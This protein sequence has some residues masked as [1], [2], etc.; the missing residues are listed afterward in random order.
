MSQS[1]DVELI[2]METLV[3]NMV[4][5]TSYQVSDLVDLARHHRLFEW[6]VGNSG[7]G[8]LDPSQRSKFGY[9]LRRFTNRI[10][11]LVEISGTTINYV[12]V[13]FSLLSTT[14]KKV[15]GLQKL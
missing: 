2:G 6:I 4:E 11:Q 15:Y 10:F 13:R 14:A 7:D 3:D 9:L 1:G 8:D 5:G 12:S